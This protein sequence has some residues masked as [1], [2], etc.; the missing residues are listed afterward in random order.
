MKNNLI[1]TRFDDIDI[2]R[3][4]GIII[5]VMGHVGFS[6]IFDVWIHTYHMP[7]FFVISGFFFRKRE[8][9]S[10]KELVL[11]KAKSLLIPYL[12]FGIFHYILWLF[13]FI[14]P[15][16]NVWEPI[17]R[18]FSFNTEHLPIAGALWFFTAL[19]FCEI[20]YNLIVYSVKNENITTIIILLLSLV[21]SLITT[22]T[23]F[24]LPLTTDIAISCLVYYHTGRYLRVF[25]DKLS[26]REKC[27]T[28]YIQTFL[29]SV[30]LM[31]INVILTFCNGYVNIKMGW[32][33]I[34]PLTWLNAFI[35]IASLYLFSIF[36]DKKMGIISKAF[37][38]IGRNSIVYL[39]LNQL[40][41][42]ILTI[43]IG[44]PIGNMG[45]L[46]LGGLLISLF[47]S[48]LTMLILSLFVF[49]FN[50]TFLKFAI[51]K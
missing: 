31:A 35:G 19:F 45:Q 44:E 21:M 37:S 10:T 38:F 30:G 8:E 14:E 47:I 34:I 7:L 39:C 29:I 4:L 27:K 49:I 25:I 15:E 36:I 33:A 28:H 40:V 11:K 46:T 17:L 22:L 51:G 48:V 9:F 20:F 24:R 12:F 16:Y 50:K 3:G 41:I 5:M 2:L 23:N 42:M 18:L 13:V 26:I 32:H 1:K 43:F 6:G